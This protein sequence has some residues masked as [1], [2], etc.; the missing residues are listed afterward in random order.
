MLPAPEF[1]QLDQT[2]AIWQAYDPAVKAELFSTSIQ[3]GDRLFLVDPIPLA[4]DAFADLTEHARIS[5][6]F[7]T[8]ANHARAAIWYAE[9]TG[10]GVLASAETAGILYD[11]EMI[12]MAPGDRVGDR[13]EVVALEGAAE[14]EIALYLEGDG[15]SLVL[16]DALINFGREGF[17]LLPA[18]YC[19]DQKSLRR[20]LRQLLD[21]S[22]ERLLFAHGAPI[23]SSA[24]ARLETLLADS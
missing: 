6:V 14:G 3:L 15:G 19:S 1:Q 20:S 5:S 2:L 4:A 8:N 23:V 12:A 22:F 7:L 17:V 10:A 21:F 11:L 18:K 13:I 9:E 24:R 16:G